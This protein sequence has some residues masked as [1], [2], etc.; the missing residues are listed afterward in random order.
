MN[1]AYYR[2]FAYLDN[3]LLEGVHQKIRINAFELFRSQYTYVII[4]NL[5]SIKYPEFAGRTCFLHLLSEKICGA[6]TRS[7]P[8]VSN[9]GSEFV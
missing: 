2:A 5:A 4:D 1:F 8:K 7:G 9:I 3:N 6:R